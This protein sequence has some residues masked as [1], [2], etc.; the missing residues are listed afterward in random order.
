MANKNEPSFVFE[1]PELLASA[2]HAQLLARRR[3]TLEH[4]L[5]NVIHS[6]LSGTELLGKSLTTASARI[7]PAEC[8]TLLQQQLGRA[9]STLT[10]MLD[11][12][13][14]VQ[15]EVGDI[16]LT[17]LVNECTHALRHQLQMMDLQTTMEAALSV[18]GHRARLKDALLC[19]LLDSIDAAPPRSKLTVSASRAESKAVLQIQHM[20]DAAKP[21]SSVMLFMGELLN[22]DD[23]LL[24][25]DSAA[26]ERRITI[27]LPLATS[28]AT[29]VPGNPR[30]LI[31]DANRDAADSLAMLVQ[32]DGY[33]AE[34]VY[35]VDTALQSARS[36]SPAAVLVDLDG[37]IDSATL[38]RKLRDEQSFGARVIGL[39]HSAEHRA[40]VGVDAQLRKPLDPAALQ[41]I[42]ASGQ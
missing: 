25:I 9:Q 26:T 28:T 34:A 7:T 5:K 17:E 15:G 4:D 3:A 22:A 33:D 6:L 23:A 1:G 41:S 13:A 32:L 27:S 37:S 8:L 35:D 31:V 30:L 12:I 11:E 38:I 18:R 24:E 39:S 40:M 16:D 21:R 29:A 42:F 14:P 36:A 20:Q 2:L 19:A 10:R